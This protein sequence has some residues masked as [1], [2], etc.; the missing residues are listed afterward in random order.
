MKPAAIACC[1]AKDCEHV[2]R[3]VQ[4]LNRA[5]G[6]SSTSSEVPPF[7]SRSLNAS[8]ALIMCLFL[9]AII[10]RYPNV[11]AAQ[12]SKIYQVVHPPS[13]VAGSQD[14]IPVTATVY[15]NDTTPGSRLVVGIL[16]AGISPQSIVPGIVISSTSPWFRQGSVDEITMPG[17]VL[18]GEIPASS[19]PTT[20]R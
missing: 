13:S 17:T 5:E 19:I 12:A 15:Y 18:C 10:S 2:V 16:D 4:N 20:S 1:L 6:I 9:V 8:N 3:W 11:Q 7:G 14:P